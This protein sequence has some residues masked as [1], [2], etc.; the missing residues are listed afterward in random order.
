MSEAPEAPRPKVDDAYWFAM[1]EDLVG[2]SLGTHEAAA[3]KL[4][5]LVLWLWG[6]YTTY[7]TVGLALAGKSLPLWATILIALAS[8]ALIAVYWGTFWV[9]APVAGHEFDPRSPDDIR[10]AFTGILEERNRRFQ[11]TLAGSVLA[12]FLVALALVVASTTK[13][14]PVGIPKLRA[15]LVDT[16]TARELS[17]LATV[18]ND[19]LARLRVEPLPGGPGRPG[20]ERSILSTSDG[21]VQTS[22]LVDPLIA[23]ARVSIEWLSEDG[24][25]RS[26]SKVVGKGASN[27]GHAGKTP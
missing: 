4:Q 14:E 15:V 2:K 3:A 12:A 7:A 17:V 20:L 26:M 27:A 1:S 22:L 19:A 21:L 25:T 10:H 6:V 11:L 8:A 24:V 16:A 23:S 18:G 13:S 9:Q 5:N